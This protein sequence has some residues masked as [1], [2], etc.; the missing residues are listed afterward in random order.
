LGKLKSR[1]MSS[2]ECVS[3]VEVIFFYLTNSI[4]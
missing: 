2:W 4:E 1:R 3:V